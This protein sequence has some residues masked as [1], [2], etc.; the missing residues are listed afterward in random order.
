MSAVEILTPRGIT[1]SG[2]FVNPVDTTNAAVIFSHSILANRDSGGHFDR[3]AAAYRRAGYATLTFD[4]SGHGVSGDDIVSI[5]SQVEDLQACSAWLKD[6]GFTRQVVHAHSFGTKAALSA[7]LPAVL[8]F[9][10]SGAQFGPLS[11]EW[12]A[13]FSPEQLD[14]LDRYGTTTI[15]D[16]S[17]G[18]RQ[19]FT[20]SK[21]TLADLSLYDSS[22]DLEHVS[23]PMLIIHDHDDEAMGLVRLTQAV[24]TSFPVGTRVD[25]VSDAAFG[26][27]EKPETLVSLALDWVKVHV[28]VRR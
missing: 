1:L 10:L 17:P 4:Y 9:V 15:P 6:Q 18:P 16:D 14:D 12:E 21:Q 3:L 27:G 19:F 2:T 25:V 7:H 26:A 11:Y 13:I 8:G 20:I 5:E 23:V 24:A 28:P 22:R